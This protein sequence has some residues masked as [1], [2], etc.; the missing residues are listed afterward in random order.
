M[1]TYE[2]K[3]LKSLAREFRKSVDVYLEFCEEKDKAPDRPY[4]GRFNARLSPELHRRAAS[5]AEVEGVSL[6]DLVGRALEREI[7]SATS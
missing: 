2:A 7:T 5:M 3:N 6:N 1:V 4:S